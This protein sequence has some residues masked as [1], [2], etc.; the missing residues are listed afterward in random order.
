VLADES[1]VRADADEHADL[2][3]ALRGGG[4]FGVVGV[5]FA[6]HPIAARTA[7][8]AVLGARRSGAL[9]VAGA[10]CDRLPRDRA[11]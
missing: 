5:Q 11:R 7:R 6:L 2:L 4:N 10:V 3:W 1:Q 8:A 9:R